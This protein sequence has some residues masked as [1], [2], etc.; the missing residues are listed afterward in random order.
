MKHVCVVINKVFRN[1]LGLQPRDKAARLENNTIH[2]NEN[3]VVFPAERN[4]INLV[5]SSSVAA[6]MSGA[7]Q[8]WDW[9]VILLTQTT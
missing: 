9:L 7:N 5:L 2:E 8:Q 4:A 3:G 6:V 1:I